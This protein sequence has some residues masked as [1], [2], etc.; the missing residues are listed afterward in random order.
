MKQSKESS[1]DQP[2][3]NSETQEP[4]LRR[5]SK[6]KLDSAQVPEDDTHNADNVSPGADA[7]SAQAVDAELVEKPQQTQP[8]LTDEDM[9]PLETLDE[10]SDFSMFLSPKVSETLRRRALQKLFHFQQLLL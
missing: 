4:F 7:Q 8:E 6:R 5:W 1:L 10:H 3:Q 9:P 2:V